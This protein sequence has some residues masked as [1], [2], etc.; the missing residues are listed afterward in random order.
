VKL[1]I[2]GADDG[3]YVQELARIAG[4]QGDEVTIHPFAQIQHRLAHGQSAL[5]TSDGIDFRT[6]DA[7]IVRSMP[8]SSLE[9]TIFRM[10]ALYAVEKQGVL[11]LNPVKSLECAIDK[12]LTLLRLT[13]AGIKVPSTIACESVDHAMAAFEALGKSVVVKPIF[14]SEGRGMVHLTDA[15]IAWRTFKTL[16]QLQAVIYLQEF[17]EHGGRDVR[18]MT[19]QDEVLG[20]ITRHNSTDF[21]TNSVLDSTAQI[22]EP[23]VIECK[24]AILAAEVTGVIFAGVDLVYAASGELYVLEVNAVPGWKALQETTGLPIAKLM[25]DRLRTHLKSRSQ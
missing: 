12:W 14:G 22:H 5:L 2:L 25:L 10:D 21:R 18:I 8:A 23:T 11:V 20:A 19:W 16:T 9:Q 15:D 13:E 1:L 4:E 7:I 6:F 17:I 3:Y 24:L